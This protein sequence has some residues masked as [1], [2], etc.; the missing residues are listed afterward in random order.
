MNSHTILGHKFNTRRQPAQITG[1]RRAQDQEDSREKKNADVASVPRRQNPRN[2]LGRTVQAQT[3]LDTGAEKKKKKGKGESTISF[4][5][6]PDPKLGFFLR[7]PTEIGF[8]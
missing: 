7:T 4:N 8:G 1:W 6:R 2:G 5:V 3:G